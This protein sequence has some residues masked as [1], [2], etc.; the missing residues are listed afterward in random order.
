MF[1]DKASRKSKRRDSF[2]AL[3]EE[4]AFDVWGDAANFDA[5]SGTA[6]GRKRWKF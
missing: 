3:A 2:E 4:D 5:W 6:F 1:G